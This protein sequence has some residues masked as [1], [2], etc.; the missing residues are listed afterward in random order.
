M[1]PL[2]EGC[3]QELA[4][5][6]EPG[7]DPQEPYSLCAACHRRLLARALRPL[8]WF[9]LAKRHGQQ[10]LLRDD[11]YDPDG[12][13][14]APREPVEASGDFPA[15]RYEA[16][17]NEAPALLDYVLT[18][19]V[20]E[21]KVW[22]SVAYLSYLISELL[23]ERYRTTRK[24]GVR[25][26]LL[27][28]GAGARYYGRELALFAWSDDPPPALLPALAQA[29]A[30]CLDFQDGF[31]RVTAAL[32]ELEESRRRELLP[33]LSY[34]RLPQILD[35]IEQSY[36]EPAVEAWG[37][38][39]AASQIDW[40]RIELW[41]ERGHPFRQIALDALLAILEP[42]TPFLRTHRPL[43][44]RPPSS[45]RFREVL[46]AA[47]EGE[48]P[49]RQQVATLLAAADFF[50]R[51]RPVPLPMITGKGDI[52]TLDRLIDIGYPGVA[53]VL[54]FMIE[55]L[56]D[57]NWPVAHR[58]EQFLISIGQPVLAEVRR[59]FATDDEVWKYWCIGLLSGLDLS[60]VEEM[61]PEL[62]ELAFRPTP[63]EEHEEVAQE[64][65]ELL[66]RMDEARQ[67]TG[68]ATP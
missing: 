57:M 50:A 60:I 15:P 45:E 17:H 19:R 37:H 62:T 31:P 51:M 5:V 6:V 66:Q 10:P 26:R 58:L 4:V 63:A 2:C 13:A 16:V 23:V 59:V 9:N 38:L 14:K 3:E 55:W 56:Q 21:Q 68:K 44:H 49:V 20:V 65:R 36:F 18:R 42:P 8:E 48:P 25:A 29:T 61:R 27:E 53:P 47:A 30:A 34:F 32:A 67:R 46:A 39:A 35:W 54:P 33:L 41:L 52:K 11:L 40:P 24:P 43:L 22:D 12:N 1:D 64:A 28:I 7:D